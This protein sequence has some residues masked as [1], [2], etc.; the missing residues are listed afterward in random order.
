MKKVDATVAKIEQHRHV[1]SHDIFNKRSIHQQ[2]VKNH[3]KKSGHKENP[4]TSASQKFKYK[5]FLDRIHICDTLHRGNGIKSFL[6]L[7]LIDDRSWTI[8]NN[9]VHVKLCFTIC[10]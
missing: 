7:F 3:L 6:G 4:G 9:D 1:S 8:Y 10:D 5:N 2:I